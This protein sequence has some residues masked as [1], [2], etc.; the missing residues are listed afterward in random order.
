MGQANVHFF[1]TPVLQEPGWQWVTHWQVFLHQGL[2]KPHRW[3]R[4]K[5]AN[6]SP[7]RLPQNFVMIGR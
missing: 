7:D 4:L 1:S 6:L 5:V 3:A 2:R